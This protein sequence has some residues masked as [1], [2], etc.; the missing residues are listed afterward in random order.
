MLNKKQTA[1]VA[2]I[3]MIKS[4]KWFGHVQWMDNDSLPRKALEWKP[5]E[6]YPNAV[7]AVGGQLKT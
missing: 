4:F 7:K 2:K 5:T 1:A 6:H 3:I